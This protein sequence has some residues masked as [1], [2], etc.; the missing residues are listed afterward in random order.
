MSNEMD[1]IIDE[2]MSDYNE[3]KDV[4]NP[5]LGKLSKIFKNYY[6]VDTGVYKTL[7]KHD[8][9]TGDVPE[10][11]KAN[12]FAKYLDMFGQL[13]RFYSVMERDDEIVSYLNKN[14]GLNISMNPQKPVQAGDIKKAGKLLTEVY[15]NDAYLNDPDNML[16][17]IVRAGVETNEMIDLS[18]AEIEAIA[19]KSELPL[20]YLNKLLAIRYA[21]E[22]GKEVDNKIE[23]I[24]ETIEYHQKLYDL[25]SGL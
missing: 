15:G 13:M 2:C 22:S 24:D 21:K 5:L 4:H 9:K 11:G 10:P 7:V 23:K 8:Y 25:A 16:K 14:F 20:T 3:I 6:G 17:T 12:E 1:N 18:K 19:E